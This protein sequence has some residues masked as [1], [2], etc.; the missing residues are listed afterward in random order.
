MAELDLSIRGGGSLL[1]SDQSG[2]MR[3]LRVAKILEDEELIKWAKEDASEILEGDPKLD[4]RPALR[5]EIVR[6]L[7][8]DA[9]EWLARA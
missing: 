2:A 7:G 8:D 4:R 1:S 5:D 9:K 3:E 6:A